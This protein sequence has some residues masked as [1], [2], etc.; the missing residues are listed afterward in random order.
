LLL[1]IH[2]HRYVC[3]EIGLKVAQNLLKI[4]IYIGQNS[5]FPY[6]VLSS[7]SGAELTQCKLIRIYR[8]FG[9]ALF[10]PL[11]SELSPEAGDIAI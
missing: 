1:S 4:V 8:R 9:E 3:A 11:Q 7:H 2:I 6:E 10:L 5:A